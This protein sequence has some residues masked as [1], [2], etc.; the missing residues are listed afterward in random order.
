MYCS[1][2]SGMCVL[3][4][5]SY[6]QLWQHCDTFSRI[7]EVYLIESFWYIWP[8]QLYISIIKYQM[9][10]FCC[11]LICL[12]VI[13]LSKQS[14]MNC[15]DSEF[16]INCD[17]LAA[18]TGQPKKCHGMM[19]RQL[20]HRCKNISTFWERDGTFWKCIPSLG[21]YKRSWTNSQFL[22]RDWLTLRP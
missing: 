2:I 5:F 13:F 19:K 7:I 4:H 10:C 15:V 1:G 12:V 17:N 21:L 8:H 16:S 6:I 11:T 18:L 14:W 9:C 22:N 3:G 20:I